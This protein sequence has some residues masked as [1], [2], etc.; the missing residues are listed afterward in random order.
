MNNKEITKRKLKNAEGKRM[1]E[2]TKLEYSKRIINGIENEPEL[3]D[4]LLKS[5][6]LTE[7]EFLN[8]LSGDTTTNI[9]FYDETLTLVKIK[10]KHNEKKLLK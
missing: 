4:S 8:Y 10:R 6:E 1:L 2:K 5:L 3:L 7:K 9:T